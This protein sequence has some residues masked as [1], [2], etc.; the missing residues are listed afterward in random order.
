[1]LEMYNYGSDVVQINFSVKDAIGNF[2]FLNFKTRLFKLLQ[3]IVGLV[4]YNVI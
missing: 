1:M 3:F 4:Q 2:I